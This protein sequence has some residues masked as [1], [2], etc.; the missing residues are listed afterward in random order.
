MHFI[1]LFAGAAPSFLDS[2]TVDALKQFKEIQIPQAR[3]RV[4]RCLNFRLDPD[5]AGT[6]LF[7][8][9]CGFDVTQPWGNQPF[10]GAEYGWAK[11]LGRL[12]AVVAGLAPRPQI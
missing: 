10:K 6:R 2:S 3:A 8:G 4:W 7:F 5:G 1:N 11:I 12:A 9:H